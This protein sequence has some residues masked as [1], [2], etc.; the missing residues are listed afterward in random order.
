M[1]QLEGGFLFNY[2]KKKKKLIV[3]NANK[4]FGFKSFCI[5]CLMRVGGSWKSTF[6]PIFIAIGNLVSL[7]EV[8]LGNLLLSP[9][10]GMTIF[11]CMCVY[12]CAYKC[13]CFISKVLA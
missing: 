13:S 5:K 8:L 2:L 1:S 4:C 6:L 11:A 3:N 9:C 7:K 12:V 10:W